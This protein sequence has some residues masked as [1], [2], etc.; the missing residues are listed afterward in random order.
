MSDFIDVTIDFRDGESE[1]F[2]YVSVIQVNDGAL[3]LYVINNTYTKEREHLGSW[4]LDTIKKW[5]KK[6]R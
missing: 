3:E 1:T 2:T 4:P 5:T 6:A